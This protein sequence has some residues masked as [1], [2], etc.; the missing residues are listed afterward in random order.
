MSFDNFMSKVRHWDNLTARWM[1][2]H[3][4]ILFFEFV[5]VIIFFIFFFNIFRTLDISANIAPEN[6]TEQILYQQSINSLI[7]IILML[8]NSFWMLFVFNGINR[9]RVLLRE[10]SYN[11]LRCKSK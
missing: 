8:L 4:Y 5:L 7:I 6:L 2:R 1:M 10:I 9:I 3:F 11:L